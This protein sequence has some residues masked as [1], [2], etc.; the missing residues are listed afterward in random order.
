MDLTNEQWSIMEKLLPVSE[1]RTARLGRPWSDRRK[2]F[3][4]APWKD[5]PP[6]YGS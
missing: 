1:V 5:L 2:V 4:G 3:N 6:R